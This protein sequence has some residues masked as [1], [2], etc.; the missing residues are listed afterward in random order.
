VKRL[1]TAM[2]EAGWKDGASVTKLAMAICA[3]KVLSQEEKKLKNVTKK[4]KKVDERFS[5]LAN[6]KKVTKE[7]TI[8]DKLDEQ[9]EKILKE[10]EKKQKQMK[11]II[12][13]F[14]KI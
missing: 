10:K 9:V 8:E 7:L 1:L 5:F 2:G 3:I 6:P 13:N 11:S 14:N 12:G 4:A